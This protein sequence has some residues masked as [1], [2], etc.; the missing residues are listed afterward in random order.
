MSFEERLIIEHMWQVKSSVSAIA[1]Y[2]DR[3]RGEIDQELKRGNILYFQ[4]LTDHELQLMSIHKRIKYSAEYAQQFVVRSN[5]VHEERHQLTPEMKRFIEDKLTLGLSPEKI[6]QLYPDDVS[7]T[8]RTI[9][10]YI[11]QGLIQKRVHSEDA[12][13]KIQNKGEVVVNPIHRNNSQDI[14]FG[15]WL[16]YVK[17][18]DLEYQRVSTLILVEEL[19][20]FVVLIRLEDK[21]PHDVYLGLELFLD[22]YFQTVHALDFKASY[23][24]DPQLLALLETYELN[25]N[26]VD[27]VTTELQQRFE[28]IVQLMP[29]YEDIV[30][31]K[32]TDLDGLSRILN[33]R[34]FFNS[35]QSIESKF[36]EAQVQEYE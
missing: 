18:E 35:L 28:E 29:N 24:G 19:S 26:L 30:Y 4:G 20:G 2:L 3:S 6:V 27:G 16:V 8:G 33:E 34:L 25:F 5:M 10:Y 14:F 36:K 15:Q 22:R 23:L 11:D 1:R 21:D 17:H 31:F 9:R 12:L 13:V 32:Q 7:V